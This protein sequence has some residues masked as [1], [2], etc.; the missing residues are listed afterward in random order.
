MLKLKSKNA[1]KIL[2]GILNIVGD[3]NE[4]E[5]LKDLLIVWAEENE[6]NIGVVM[7]CFRVA[8]VGKLSGPDLFEICKLLNKD[9]ILIRISKAISYF[10]QK[11]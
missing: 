11:T 10:K 3:C 5:T 9:I 7:Q 1:D 6:I 8:L 4:F 2:E